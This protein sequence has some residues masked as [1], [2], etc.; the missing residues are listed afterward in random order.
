MYNEV[1]LGNKYC[2]VYLRVAKR[3]ALESSHHEEKVAM[4]GDGC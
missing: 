2:T 1:T 4:H 3:I